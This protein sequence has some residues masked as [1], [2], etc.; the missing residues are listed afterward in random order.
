MC[1]PR[2]RSAPRRG[3]CSG[4]GVRLRLIVLCSAI[5]AL[6]CGRRAKE[7]PA[8]VRQPPPRPAPLTGAAATIGREPIIITSGSPPPQGDIHERFEEIVVG[9]GAIAMRKRVP[10]ANT[11]FRITNRGTQAHTI[12]I[13]DGE[14][15]AQAHA[16]IE[17]S[18]NAIVEM[19][20]T[21]ARYRVFC[22]LPGHHER[23]SFSTYVP[24]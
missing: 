15:A 6:A 14:N 5:A 11:V 19:N 22:S 8:E 17:P 12:M 13:V 9:D 10:R 3:V 20:L 4:R 23:A 21:A 16:A 2:S 24:R 1:R 7:P 18:Q